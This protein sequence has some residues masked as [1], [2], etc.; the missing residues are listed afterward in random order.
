MN[1]NRGGGGVGAGC[2]RR[3]PGRV[4]RPHS[5]LGRLH[6]N[7]MIHIRFTGELN[8]FHYCHSSEEVGG[9][10]R[11]AGRS[12]GPGGARL[13]P[14]R[15]AAPHALQSFVDILVCPEVAER[16]AR[17]PEYQRSPPPARRARTTASTAPTPLRPNPS[18][19]RDR[20]TGGG[21]HPRPPSAR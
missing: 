5:G 4:S 2:G 3:F 12:V 16:S 6:P 9:G 20:A 7:A 14:R 10:T 8:V 15:R 17:T 18:L 13:R 21:A 19:D 1:I 11:R